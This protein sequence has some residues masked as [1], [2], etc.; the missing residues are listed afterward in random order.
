MHTERV[1]DE[2]RSTQRAATRAEPYPDNAAHL[3]DE[4]RRLDV[5]LEQRI[6]AY[7]T[8]R[9]LV[10]G[11]A[12]SKGLFIS[13]AEVDALLRRDHMPESPKQSADEK[14]RGLARLEASIAER[15]AASQR[16]GVYLALPHLADCF[17]LSPPEL[18]AV[19]ICLAPELD[20][21]YDTLY[22]YMQDDITR[23]RPSVD[24]VLNILCTT[25][26]ERWQTRAGAPIRVAA[27]PD[28]LRERRSAQP[29][30]LE[31]PGAIPPVG[32]AHPWPYSR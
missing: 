25:P 15:V 9:P 19:V 31:R 7:R 26:V 24:L 17:E 11:L 10:E 21:K 28:T 12:A 22:A 20:T 1:S 13:D 5:L 3:L 29:V 27:Q 4:L 2:D 32:S 16:C 23:R 14:S 8:S 30:R 18:A 6:A